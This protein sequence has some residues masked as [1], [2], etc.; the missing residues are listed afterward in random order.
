MLKGMLKRM[1]KEMAGAR[2][3]SPG[4][5]RKPRPLPCMAA[6]VSAGCSGAVRVATV[7]GT[8]GASAHIS[9]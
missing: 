4:P 7:T 3:R 2:D 9:S 6:Q 5:G 8:R 1:R